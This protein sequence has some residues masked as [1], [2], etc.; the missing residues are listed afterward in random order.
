[1]AAK[2]AKSAGLFSVAQIS[3]TIIPEF[4]WWRTAD[5]KRLLCVIEKWGKGIESEYRVEKLAIVERGI[6][7]KRYVNYK[8]FLDQVKAGKLIEV[9]FSDVDVYDDVQVY[10]RTNY[11]GSV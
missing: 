2:K 3:F 4:S 7:E 5:R 11:V 9:H 1:M 8:T 10:P 6:Q